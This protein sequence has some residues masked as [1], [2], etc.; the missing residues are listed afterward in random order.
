MDIYIDKDGTAHVTEVWNVKTDKGT[1]CYHP[2]YNLGK[3]EIKNLSVS[4]NLRQ[5]EYD[6]NWNPN[7]NFR[8]KAN[9]CGINKINNGIELCWGISNYGKNTY[10]VKYEIT[11]FV[12]EL[13]DSQMIYWTLIPYEFSNKIEKASIKIYADNAFENTT[14]VWGYGDYGGPCYVKDGFIYMESKG[15]INKDEY[16]TILVKLKPEAFNTGSYLNKN[17]NYYLNMAEQGARKYEAK[18]KKI[19]DTFKKILFSS[20]LV[21]LIPIIILIVSMKIKANLNQSG[22]KKR[23]ISIIDVVQILIIFIIVSCIYFYI[24][25]RYN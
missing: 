19:E 15:G 9:T 17:F 8:S 4:D 18:S 3:S 1:E 7:W 2:Y 21:F 13:T 12:S 11:N 16:M 5:Y 20:L 14:D 22:Q 6:A 10:T 23:R 25:E 24:K